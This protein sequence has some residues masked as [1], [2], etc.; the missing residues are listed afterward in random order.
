MEGWEDRVLYIVI[1]FN[2]FPPA[3]RSFQTNLFRFRMRTRTS[4]LARFLLLIDIVSRTAGIRKYLVELL[5]C[6]RRSMR[7]EDFELNHPQFP[8]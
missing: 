8:L 1:F 4:L 7:S 5:S 6:S 3:R 2:L